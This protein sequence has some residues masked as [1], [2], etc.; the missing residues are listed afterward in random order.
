MLPL[1]TVS[2]VVLYLAAALCAHRGWRAPA[3]LV[4]LA[5]LLHAAAL[6]V[7]LFRYG[8]LTIGVTENLSLISWLSALLLWTACWRQPLQMLGIGLYPIAAAATALATLLPAP[9]IALPARDWRMETHIV[10]SVLSAGVMTLAALQSLA[11]AAQDRLLHAHTAGSWVTRLPPL[12]TMERL[13]F[14][15]ILLGWWLLSCTL[16]SG[17]L[18]V[19]NLFAQHLVHKTVLSILAWAVFGVLLLGRWRFGWRGRRAIR[20][21]LSGYALLLLSYFGSKLILEWVL[22]RHWG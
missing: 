11:L 16:L 2:T 1:L 12:Q 21:T 4:P 3:W 19:E 14:G 6:N 15:S 22:G 18:F 10:L 9:Q 17:F 5:L 8:M 13:L 20:W 7:Q